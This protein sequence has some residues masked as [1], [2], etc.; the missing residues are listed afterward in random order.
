MGPGWLKGRQC[1]QYGYTGK[2]TVHTQDGEKRGGSEFQHVIQNNLLFRAH[3]LQNSRLYTT[4]KR[5]K[6]YF[7]NFLYLVFF[8][9]QLTVT[10]SRNR[11]HNKKE[12]RECLLCLLMTL[13]EEIFVLTLSEASLQQ[14]SPAKYRAHL[15]CTGHHLDTLCS[16]IQ[17]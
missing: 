4:T 17:P 5:T 7:W 12:T 11:S 3:E 8:G 13:S 16:L 2:R 1:I 6:H 9:L 15:T 10:K 14:S